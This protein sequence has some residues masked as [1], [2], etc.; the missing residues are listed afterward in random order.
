MPALIGVLRPKVP[1]ADIARTPP[2]SQPSNIGSLSS[3]NTITIART[4]LLHNGRFESTGGGGGQSLTKCSPGTNWSRGSIEVGPFKLMLPWGNQGLQNPNRIRI[5]CRD[6][7]EHPLVK[8]LAEAK[9]PRGAR[10]LRTNISP[11]VIRL[12]IYRGFPE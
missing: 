7:A 8:Q 10:P 6:E 4:D 12:V 2:R 11:L 1:Y 5:A 9:T 3:S